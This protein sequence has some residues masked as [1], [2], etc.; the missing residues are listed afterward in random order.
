VLSRPDAYVFGSAP[1]P[2]GAADLIRALREAIDGP[3]AGAPPIAE[4]A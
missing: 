3:A 2:A 4:A 1:D